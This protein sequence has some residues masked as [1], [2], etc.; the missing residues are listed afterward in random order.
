MVSRPMRWAQ[1]GLFALPVLFLAL[2]FVYPLL[3]ILR[4]SLWP[5][6]EFVWAPVRNVLGAEWFWSVFWFTTWQAM[7]STVLTLA[8]GLPLAAIFAR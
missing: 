2:F 3:G 5:E 7:A 6:G 8:F 4:L 1:V